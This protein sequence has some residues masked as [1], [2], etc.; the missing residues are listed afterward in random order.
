MSDDDINQG[1]SDSLIEQI[2]EMNRAI[3]GE[4]GNYPPSQPPQ[5][6]QPP[7]TKRFRSRAGDRD[8]PDPRWLVEG[9]IPEDSDVAIY[10][11]FAAFKTFVAIDLAMSIAQGCKALGMFDVVESGPV[12]FFAGE[13]YSSMVKKRA[14]AWEIGHGL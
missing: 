3:R 12:F 9:L 4:A 14:T 13:G 6:P 2:I 5:P 10:A 8:A 1:A 11:P 7:R